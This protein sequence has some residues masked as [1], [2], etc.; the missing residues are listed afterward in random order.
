MIFKLNLMTIPQQH[1]AHTFP[2]N[3]SQG[4][5][6]PE[7]LGGHPSQ[8]NLDLQGDPKQN[9]IRFIFTK[10]KS[11][12]SHSKYSKEN[13][14]RSDKILS[15]QTS[16]YQWIQAFTKDDM[17][18][19]ENPLLLQRSSGERKSLWGW[20]HES[21]MRLCCA[22]SPAQY[23]LHLCRCRSPHMTDSK[24]QPWIKSWSDLFPQVS[25]KREAAKSRWTLTTI[26]GSTNY[27]AQERGR[28]REMAV[29]T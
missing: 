22:P 6:L 1:N 17:E 2:N 4:A 10:Q 20:G 14:T 26:K 11:T 25:F 8:W 29:L 28:E 24:I 13:E 9:I 12:A 19:V 27:R 3:C 18:N 7:H 21:S 16:E 23:I 5:V 15:T